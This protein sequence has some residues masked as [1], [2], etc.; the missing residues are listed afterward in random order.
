MAE[1]IRNSVKYI[2]E[3]FQTEQWPPTLAI[4][5]NNYSRSQNIYAFSIAPIV[6]EDTDP[7]NYWIVWGGTFDNP[8]GY[9]LQMYMDSFLNEV[10]LPSNL[11]LT[12]KSFYIDESANVV[13][14]NLPKNPW[15]YY[16]AYATVYGNPESTFS[17]APK[18]GDDLSDIYYDAVRVI[19]R[20]EV[21][22]LENKLNDTISGITVYSGFDI[23]IDNADG[24]YDGMN[25][26]AYFNT[27]LQISKSS[28]SPTRISDFNRIRFGIVE[29]INVGFGRMVISAVDPFYNMNKDYCRKFSADEFENIDTG[30]VNDNIPVGWGALVGVSPVEVDIDTSD[31]PEWIDYVAL[32]KSH[33]TSV[34]T[35][36]D[37]DG[38]S[39]THSFNSTTGVIRVTELDGDGEVIEAEYMDV[40]GKTDNSI[41]EIIVEALE[42]NE[43][44]SYIEGIW[45][46]TETDLYLAYC[47]D[48][49]IYFDGGTTRDLLE[50]VL[51]NDM[52]QLMRKNDGRITIRR[53]GET[54][55]NHQLKS[56]VISQKPQKNFKDATKYF[57]SSAKVLYNRNENTDKW[58]SNYLNDEEEFQ[59]FAETRKSYLGSFE[60][61][62]KLEADASDLC[63]RIMD[64]FGEIRETITIG[65]GVNTFDVDL[66]DTIDIEVNVNGREFSK[67]SR[68]IVKSCDPGQ[69]V[70]TLEGLEI[71]NPL[72]FDGVQATLDDVPWLVQLTY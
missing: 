6:T 53:W 71:F 37:K 38:N 48:V 21:P 58:E 42:E 62:F 50:Q 63:D 61:D 23:S 43:N 8:T 31:P 40:T 70:L 35:V 60:T 18:D 10:F 14:M 56:W 15:R 46:V 32:D 52:V 24:M 59:I 5:P 7:T 33:I 47:P 49:A 30:T 54:Y 27:P 69:D 68:W 34:Q 72:T 67:Y 22:T 16:T 4:A 25:I 55:T 11:I 57:C 13:Y 28:D 9:G 2:A 26:L 3:L 29:D 19:P 64:R 1:P 12:E 39:L 36:Y 65:L 41:G 45:D 66:L 17:T 20:M 44:L 51:K